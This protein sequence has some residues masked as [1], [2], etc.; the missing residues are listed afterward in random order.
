[1]FLFEKTDIGGGKFNDI[2]RGEILSLLATDSA[3]NTRN[4]LNECHITN[5]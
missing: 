4:G 1:M 3:S 2:Q 5:L